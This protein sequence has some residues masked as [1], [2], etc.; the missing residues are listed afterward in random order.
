[1]IRILSSGI[2][3]IKYQKHTSEE[4]ESSLGS[5]TVHGQSFG[6]RYSVI[7]QQREQVTPAE[8]MMVRMMMGRGGWRWYTFL[9]LRCPTISQALHSYCP[10][11][12]SQPMKCGFCYFPILQMREAIT[13]RLSSLPT[14]TQQVRGRAGIPPPQWGPMVHTPPNLSVMLTHTHTSAKC[15]FQ[16]LRKSRDTGSSA[17]GWHQ[18][19]KALKQR[20]LLIS[21][22]GPGVISFDHPF[23]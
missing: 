16:F 2:S 1:M 3:L 12:S 23:S 21:H 10:L 6:I 5:A 19:L 17:A 8:Y 15:L 13:E 7:C 22:P 4:A 14:V 9:E 11:E 18:L 20:S